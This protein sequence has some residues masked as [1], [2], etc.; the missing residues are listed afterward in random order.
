MAAQPPTPLGSGWL[1]TPASSHTSNALETGGCT[2]P[3]GNEAFV[4]AI[5]PL[6]LAVVQEPEHVSPIVPRTRHYSQEV[7]RRLEGY[8]TRSPA[9]LRLHEAG[10]PTAIVMSSYPPHCRRVFTCLV[11]ARLF[12]S[13]A[14]CL[15]FVGWT[16]GRTS[17]RVRRTMT[18]ACRTVSPKRRVRTARRQGAPAPDAVKGQHP[19]QQGAELG[20]TPSPTGVSTLSAVPCRPVL[21]CACTHR[22]LITRPSTRCCGHAVL[23]GVAALLWLQH[24]HRLPL[25]RDDR[26]LGR[27]ELLERQL[28]ATSDRRHPDRS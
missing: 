17:V 23:A 8:S 12:G 9:E 28:D 20:G 11:K 1:E 10:T 19:Q 24:V 14:S 26:P 16:R 5:E 27:R 22:E 18:D 25:H 15:A 7:D 2:K 4:F 13:V 6:R 3:N 21:L